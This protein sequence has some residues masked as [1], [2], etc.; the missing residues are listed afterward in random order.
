MCLI[1]I[2]QYMC[3]CFDA[4]LVTYVLFVCLC[5]CA[6]YWWGFKPEYTQTHYKSH[7]MKL[8]VSV[9]MLFLYTGGDLN[10][11]TQTHGDLSRWGPKLRSPWV[12][13]L[14]NHTE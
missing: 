4:S 9:C 6:G 10:L 14:I 11:N 7:R 8:F 3:M 12:N 13:K 5:A 2:L 1:H